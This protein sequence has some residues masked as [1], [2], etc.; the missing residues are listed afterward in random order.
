MPPDDTADPWYADGLRFECTQCGNC[1][2]GP[3]GYVLVSDLET[4]RL[5]I[6]MGLSVAEFISACTKTTTY[7][8]SLSERET[9]NGLDCIFLDRQTLPGKA[10]CAVYEDRPSQCRT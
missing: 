9:P 5:A 8:R 3:E 1:C 4:E 2:S 7:G 6:R 10:L